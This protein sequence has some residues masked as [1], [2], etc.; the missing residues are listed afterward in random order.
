MNFS[1]C[2]NSLSA[3]LLLPMLVLGCSDSPEVVDT[4]IPVAFKVDSSGTYFGDAKL[5]FSVTEFEEWGQSAE[6]LADGAI[7]LTG[8]A[9]VNLP[10]QDSH[11]IEA[12]AHI[13][14]VSKGASRFF[15]TLDTVTNVERVYHY[16]TNENVVVIGD[17]DGGV[18]VYGNPD[19]SYDV[20]TSRFDT[21]ASTDEYVRAS[22]GYEA[23]ALV[24]KYNEFTSG[25][26]HAMLLAVSMGQHKL[27]DARSIG[28]CINPGCSTGCADAADGPV[29][30]ELFDELC[31]CAVCWA[32]QPA[33]GTEGA[34]KCDRCAAALAN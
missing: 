1:S 32:F 23:Y 12:I 28:V 33:L 26:P 13:D 3:A 10:G 4:A 27:A 19:G 11:E 7:E 17:F 34:E 18:F 6:R 22:D 8:S 14:P 15:S 9:M 5:G 25:S 31:V 21:P 2:I 24:N 16:D 29:I 30:C 20:V